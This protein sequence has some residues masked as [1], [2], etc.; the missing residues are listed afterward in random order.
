MKYL[1]IPP[2]NKNM[3]AIFMWALAFFMLCSAEH[4]VP[5]L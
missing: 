2:Q 5:E 1:K 3:N 4:Y